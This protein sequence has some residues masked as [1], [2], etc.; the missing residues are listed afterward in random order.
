MRGKVTHTHIKERKVPRM[1]QGVL[2][3]AIESGWSVHHVAMTE[4]KPWMRALL[5]AQVSPWGP[6][7]CGCLRHR[8]CC[9]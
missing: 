9:N 4:L 8:C 1:L 7:P 6:S 5:V 3:H 2:T